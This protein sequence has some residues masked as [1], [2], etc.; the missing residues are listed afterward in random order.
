MNKSPYEVFLE[1]IDLDNAVVFIWFDS[2]WIRVGKESYQ[3]LG[4]LLGDRP[5]RWKVKLSVNCLFIS[6]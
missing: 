4:V 3:I 1:C 6:L 2:N 5:D